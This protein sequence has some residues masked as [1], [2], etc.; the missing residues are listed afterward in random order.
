M[1]DIFKYATKKKLRFDIGK[2]EATVEQLW[3]MPLRGKG[4]QRGLDDL[5]KKLGK[6]IKE[7]EMDEE[8]SFLDEEPKFGKAELEVKFAVVKEVITDRLAG[9]KRAEDSLKRKHMK[10]K[11]DRLIGEKEDEALKGSSV[12]DLKKLRDE[13]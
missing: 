9:I 8:F 10:E 2:G 11:Y 1:A 6:E 4:H 7:M 3:E 13:V 5:A 12:E